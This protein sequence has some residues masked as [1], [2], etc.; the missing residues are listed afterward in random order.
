M[1]EEVEVEEEVTRKRERERERERKREICFARL[2][3]WVIVEGIVTRQSSGSV[4]CYLCSP[5]FHIDMLC[6][7]QY[8]VRRNGST[9]SSS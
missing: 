7:G 6:D 4:P 8:V 3:D 9:P 1:E 5:D 2:F